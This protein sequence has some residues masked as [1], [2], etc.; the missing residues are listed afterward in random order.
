MPNPFTTTLTWEL[1]IP[2]AEEAIIKI[3]DISGKTCLMRQQYLNKGYNRINFS[4]LSNL[5][6]GYL[7]Y[8]IILSNEV[9][10]GKILKIE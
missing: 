10:S 2:Q 8:Q 5:P 4:N 7:N 1:N 3:T 6:I 9:I